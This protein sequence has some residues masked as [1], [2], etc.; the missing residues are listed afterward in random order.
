VSGKTAG[1]RWAKKAESRKWAIGGMG[2]GRKLWVQHFN[3]KGYRFCFFFFC[4][5]M[6]SSVGRSCRVREDWDWRETLE[7][8][9]AFFFSFMLASHFDLA[10]ANNR[11]QNEFF[12]AIVLARNTLHVCS[13]LPDC[14]VE[15]ALTSSPYRKEHL[16]H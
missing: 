14:V 7:G 3:D 16:S 5:C 10:A 12:E 13:F 15:R 11:K 2:L 6:E 8:N 4:I 9:E 1:G